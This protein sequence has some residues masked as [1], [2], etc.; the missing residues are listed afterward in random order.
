MSELLILWNQAGGAVPGGL[1]LFL[2]LAAFWIFLAARVLPNTG[3]FGE[4]SPLHA[5]LIGLALL[6]AGHMVL[7]AR[8]TPAPGELVLSVWPVE[9]PSAARAL[10]TTAELQL[11]A[12]KE[13]SFDGR[14]VRV[15]VNRGILPAELRQA[16]S[17]AVADSMMSA[18]GA[19]LLVCASLTK[20][21]LVIQSWYRRWRVTR[22]LAA[23]EVPIQAATIEDAVLAAREAYDSHLMELLEC[24]YTPLPLPRED[25]PLYGV[26]D[27]STETYTRMPAAPASQY[28][29]VRRASL[30]FHL[31]VD[32]AE[33]VD[34]LN[35]GMEEAQAAGVELWLLAA[36]WFS[37][38]GEWEQAIQA[39]ENA[40][41]AD[42]AHPQIYWM[43]SH[44]NKEGRKHFGFS[45]ELAPLRRSNQLQPA[46]LPTLHRLSEQLARHRRK[47]EAAERAEAALYLCPR[48]TE[49]RLLRANLAISLL[50]Y[51]RAIDLF[52]GLMSDQPRDPRAFIN[53][54]QLYFMMDEYESAI[55]PLAEA[56][57]LGAPPRILHV[58]GVC[59]D[60]LDHKDEAIH[61]YRRRM[62]LGGRREELEATR[63]KLAAHFPEMQPDTEAEDE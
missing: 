44:L 6:F 18:L 17:K 26:V 11:S 46:Y 52:R 42:P 33:V 38:K 40:M 34:V 47:G 25:L 49:L 36:E 48:D 51:G 63:Q 10:S 13:L 41:A 23:A 39:L 28:A 12:N 22:L 32:A 31:G 24:T 55:P 15:Q 56:V 3:A 58:L 37:Y 43:I 8:M 62:M 1:W 21:K 60:K 5:I 29:A 19:D 53:L 54:G 9:G 7:R 20:D 45:D 57:S 35:A 61:Y 16:D 4:R 30:Q 2:V 14:A 27:D 59:H 50:Q